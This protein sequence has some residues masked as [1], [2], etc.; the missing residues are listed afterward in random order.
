MGSLLCVWVGNGEMII[1]K[2]ERETGR[3]RV[4]NSEVRKVITERGD[5]FEAKRKSLCFGF[6]SEEFV[7]ISNSNKPLLSL[8]LS[9]PTPVAR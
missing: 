3:A 2:R 9:V 4:S 1:N 5:I 6:N 7:R 8:S